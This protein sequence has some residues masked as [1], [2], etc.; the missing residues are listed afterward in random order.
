MLL[1]RKSAGA[2]SPAPADRAAADEFRFGIGAKL[3]TAFG[4][5]AAMTVVATTVAIVSFAATESG[6]QRVARHEVPLMEDT[7]RLSVI[8]GEISTAAARFVGADTAEEHAAIAAVI[9]ARREDLARIMERVRA[10]RGSDAAFAKVESTARTLEANLDGLKNAISTRTELRDRLEQKAAELHK[11]HTEISG[12]LTPAVDDSYFDVVAAADSVGKSGDKV[13][14]T[15]VDHDLPMLQAVIEIGS[16]TNLVTGL[17][18][19]SALSSSPSIQALLEDRFVASAHRAE[20]LLKKLPADGQFTRLRSQIGELLAVAH[21]KAA[22]GA[23]NDADARNDP[24][25]RPDGDIERLNKIFRAQETLAG[26]LIQLADDLNFSLVMKGEEAANR[27]SK[28][29]K[30]LVTRQ[31]ADLRN[32]LEMVAQ[33]HLLTSLLSEGA[34]AKDAAMIVPLRDRFRASSDVLVKSSNAHDDAKIKA[35]IEALLKFGAGPDSIFALHGRELEA[36]AVAAA[37][38]QRNE[39]LQGELNKAVAVVVADSETS[40]KQSSDDLMSGL[41]RDRNVLLI[42][43]LGSLLLAAGI[44]VFYVQKN[45]LRR[46]AALGD[47]MQRLSSGETDV[48]LAAATDRDEIGS[49]ARSVLV[50]RDAAVSKARLEREAEEQRRLS[51]ERVEAERSKAAAAQ[52]KVAEEQT[53]IITRLAAGLS[54]L[55]NGDFT[56]RLGEGFSGTAAQIKDDFNAMAERITGTIAEIKATAL[57]VGN[58]ATEI[59]T[60]TDD[61]SARAEQQ[62]ASLEQTSASTEE[63]S[64][65]VKRNAE[66]AQ[67]ARDFAGNTCDAAGRSGEV[68]TKAVAAMARIDESSRKISDTTSIIDEIARQTNLLALNAAV[69]AARAGEAGRGFAVVAA[70]VRSLAQRSSQAAKDITALIGSSNTLVKEGVDLVNHAGQSLGEI[71][72]SIRKVAEIVGAIAD[73][74]VEQASGLEQVNKALTQMDETTQQNSALV[75]ENAATAK[76][77]ERQAQAMN[78]RVTFFRLRQAAPAPARRA[79][80]EQALRA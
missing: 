24:D 48:T 11:I 23:G 70:E 63:I 7:L 57:E 67:Q 73:A 21:F 1:K 30:E 51:E 75:E 28:V 71:V 20:K 31:I 59:S 4:V 79:A 6:F 65:I 37:A 27:T 17:L 15:I 66:R 68:V 8:S 54:A 2:A 64:A 33:V 46:L 38:V 44:G 19:A 9:A 45:V 32:T 12:K 60:S 36:H 13:V 41:H 78:E 3:K 72:K 43:A 69:E 14:R 10:A 80:G 55:S 77:L 49:M 74:S 56:F 39:A 42:F 53:G 34:V 47:A 18:T 52:A 76:T 50:F 61:L 26:L 35:A 62:V 58:A 40:M 16:E 29:V 25:A 22:A 5:T